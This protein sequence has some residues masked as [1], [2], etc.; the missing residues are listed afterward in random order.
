MI[1]WFKARR[2][3]PV[4]VPCLAGYAVIVAVLH[5]ATV[6]FP[7]LLVGGANDV[8]VLLLAP[9]PLTS[10]LL[11]SLTS[12]LVEGEAA[13]CRR[14]SSY[15]TALTLLAGACATAVGCVVGQ[16]SGGDDAWSVGRNTLFLTGLT[17]LVHTVAPQGAAAVPVGWVLTVAFVGFD[18]FHQAHAWTVLPRPPA[19][20]PALG[21]ALVVFAAGLVAHARHRPR[22]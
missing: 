10:G 19:D 3:A 13:A 5:G 18:Q 7:S 20:V 12:R 9:V 14:V 16:V 6:E 17:L 8:P 1:W 15:D 2:V 21:A 4:V 22:P 11:V